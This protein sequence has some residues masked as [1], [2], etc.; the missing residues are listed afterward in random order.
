MWERTKLSHVLM[1]LGLGE[2]EGSGTIRFSLGY[3][4]MA[5]G[6]TAVADALAKMVRALRLEPQPV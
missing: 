5:A 4:N 3:A 6:I 2:E 1:A